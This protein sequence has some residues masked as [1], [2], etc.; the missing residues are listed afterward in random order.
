MDNLVENT[1][2]FSKRLWQGPMTVKVLAINPTEDEL[3]AMYN[4]KEG[5]EVREVNYAFGEGQ[6]LDV[7]FQRVPALLD[8]NQEKP[9]LKAAFFVEDKEVVNKDET[10]KQYV[11]DKGQS[12]Y[13]ADVNAIHAAND[14]VPDTDADRWRK[15]S[16]EGLR[17]AKKGEV[18]L[19]NFVFNWLN[20]NKAA[21]KFALESFSK[22]CTGNFGELKKLVAWANERSKE[23]IILSGVKDDKYQAVYNSVLPYGYGQKQYDKWWKDANGDYGFKASFTSTLQEYQSEA[24]PEVAEDSPFETATAEGQKLW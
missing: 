4:M 19:L 5:T 17:V 9:I 11:N 14:N 7:Y 22:I 24:A 13:F 6:R 18:D 10:K 21:N 2:G 12:F 15:F 16:F 20:L 23:C 3:K 1:G 8:A